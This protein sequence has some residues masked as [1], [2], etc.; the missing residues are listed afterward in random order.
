M[1][2]SE[3]ITHVA[4]G[5]FGVFWGAWAAVVPAV[6]ENTGASKAAL[7]LAFAFVTVGSIPAMLVAGRAV[8]RYGAKAVGAACGAFAVTSVLP[9]LADSVFALAAALAVAGAASG[10]FD[11]AVN[12]R[13][14]RLEAESGRRLMPLTHAWYAVGVLAG[15]V[16]AGLARSAGAGPESVLAVVSVLLLAT[17]AALYVD[18]FAPAAERQTRLRLERVLL[19]LGLA[20][21]ACAIV[22]GGLENWSALFLERTLHARP[23]VSGLAP[24]FFGAAM[25]AGR[26]AAH[27]ARAVSD[28]ALFTGGTLVAAGGLALAAVAPNAPVALAGLPSAAPASR[29]RRRCSFARPA[30]IAPTPAARSP[31]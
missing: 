21:A 1:R 19:L 18:E 23:A 12:A 3:T 7:G 2:R 11:V 6:Q 28:R 22:E 5:M 24:G 27:A 20:G 25:A 15:A 8:D 9:G 31:R 13:A 10:A 29:S 4:F 26:F 17:A 30:G 16:S 14:S